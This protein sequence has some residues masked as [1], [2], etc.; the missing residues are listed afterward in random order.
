[1]W[2]RGRVLVGDAGGV[3]CPGCDA[4]VDGHG[5]VLAAGVSGAELASVSG[6]PA[7]ECGDG[8]V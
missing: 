5:G 4:G 6:V 2:A 3:D 8:G 7:A 1:M